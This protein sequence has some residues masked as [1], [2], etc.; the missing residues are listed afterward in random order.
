MFKDW[1]CCECGEKAISLYITLQ[2]VHFAV[3]EFPSCTCQI[4]AMCQEHD[5]DRLVGRPGVYK[6][7]LAPKVKAIAITDQERSVTFD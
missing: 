4:V 2:T 5:H 6:V 3:N 7:M 1:S